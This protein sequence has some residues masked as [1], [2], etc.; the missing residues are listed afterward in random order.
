VTHTRPCQI[1]KGDRLTEISEFWDLVLRRMF[2]ANSSEP[3]STRRVQLLFCQEFNFGKPSYTFSPQEICEYDYRYG[4][5]LNTSM[6]SHLGRIFHR[7]EVRANPH[8]NLKMP[9]VSEERALVKKPKY[10]LLFPLLDRA[11]VS[12]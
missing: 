8:S 6:G 10:H 1:C 11:V 7:R 4:S 2:P 3:V 12:N 5:R 9:T